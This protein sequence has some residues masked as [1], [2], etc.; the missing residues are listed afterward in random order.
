MKYRITNQ[1]LGTV[2]VVDKLPP[3]MRVG[4]QDIGPVWNNQPPPKLI[5]EEVP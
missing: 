2:V 3:G 5:V 4:V 1:Q